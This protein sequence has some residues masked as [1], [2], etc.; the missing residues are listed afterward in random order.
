MSVLLSVS[1]LTAERG[2]RTLFKGLSFSVSGGEVLHVIGPNGSGKTTLIRILAGLVNSGFSGEVVRDFPLLYIGHQA[3]LKGQLTVLENLLLDLSG[4]PVPSSMLLRD[5]LSALELDRFRNCLVS[6][7]SVGQ[8]RRVSLARIF[9]T[10]HLIWLL[11]E[12]FTSLDRR[13]ITTIERCVLDHIRRG[14]AVVVSSHHEFNLPDVKIVTIN[15]EA[16]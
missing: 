15:L 5:A 8:R 11:D 2:Q 4:W 12:P 10:K 7:L 1:D 9:F 14:G 16:S 3:A 6:T 13:T